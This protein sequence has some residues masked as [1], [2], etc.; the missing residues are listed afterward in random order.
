MTSKAYPK[1]FDLFRVG[2]GL[3][4]FDLLASQPW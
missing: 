2:V 4:S 1:I 3:L